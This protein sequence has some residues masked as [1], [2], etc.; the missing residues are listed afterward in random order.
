MFWAAA[1]GYLVGAE[2]GSLFL[3]HKNNDNTSEQHISVIEA[4]FLFIVMSF[5]GK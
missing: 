5:S 3:Q 4:V 1:S 2:T